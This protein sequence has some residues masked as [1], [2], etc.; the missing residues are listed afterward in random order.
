MAKPAVPDT[1]EQIM[2]VA[3]LRMRSHGYHGFSFREIAQDIGIKSASVHYH[4]P[5]KSDLA[6]ATTERYTERFI[7]ALGEAK[8]KRPLKKKV[9]A[10]KA[11]FRSALVEDDLMCLC[12]VLGAE[13]SGIPEPVSDSARRFFESVRDWLRDA[14]LED[15]AAKPKAR[16]LQTLATLEGALIVA[17]TL[18]DFAAFDHSV[19]RL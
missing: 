9:A 11:A 19:A 6:T 13:V 7:D 10:V 15:G 1:R 14:Y 17:R 16:A 2:D 4:F 18:N 12:G 5:S 8:D 3:E